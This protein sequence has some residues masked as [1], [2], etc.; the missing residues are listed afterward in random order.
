MPSSPNA[1]D[2][3]ADD[4]NSLIDEARAFIDRVQ[5][6][7]LI[8]RAR[9]ERLRKAADNLAV[10]L[11]TFA[12]GAE[13]KQAATYE[14]MKALAERVRAYSEELAEHRNVKR[15]KERRE[16]LARSYEE[17]L[18]DLKHR[19]VAR[20]ASLAQSRQLKPTNY[21]RN[22][23]HAANGLVA[24]LL[25]HFVLTRDAA[26]MVLG[27]IF[28]VYA[29][30]EITR[31]F[32]TRW[33][34]FLVDKVFGAIS[35]PSERYRINSATVYLVALL[36]ITWFFDKLAVEAAILVLGFGDPMASLVGKRWGRRKLFRDKSYAGTLGFFAAGFMAVG[37][38]LFFSLPAFGLLHVVGITSAI[39]AVGAVTE[40]LSSRIDDNFSIP[41]AC[42]AIGALLL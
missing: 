25:Y 12:A 20:S 21:M 39:V 4:L 3:Q 11:A 35:R 10:K 5:S 6:P 17:L 33:N 7:R 19:R 9:S 24:V 27:T 28:A 29:T 40:L 31:R 36:L 23:F 30:L 34:D 2:L 18:I 37:T 42:A 1:Q 8:D 22:I 26:L 14:S 13:K 32:S 41:I 15:L 16:T 38:L